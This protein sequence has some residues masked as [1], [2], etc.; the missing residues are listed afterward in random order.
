MKRGLLQI[1]W[2]VSFGIFVIFL[3]LL[4]ITFGPALTQEYDD[5]YLKSIAQKGF[6]EASFSEVLKYPIFVDPDITGGQDVYVVELP[7]KLKAVGEI[8]KLVVL[9]IDSSVIGQ[10]DLVGDNIIFYS[11]SA[12]AGSVNTFYLL[13]S[14]S[15]DSTTT[16]GVVPGSFDYNITFGVEEKIVGFS[17]KLFMDLSTLGYEEFKENLTYPKRKDISVRIYNGTDPS[18]LLYEYVEVNPLENDDVYVIKWADHMIG[19][20]GVRQPILVSI[21]TW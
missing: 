7:E 13:Y 19:E 15:F 3:L 21:G 20:N 4:F 5:D 11:I 6:K 2:M 16:P 12:V 10:R 8:S 17:E 1:D 14:D 18:I 9:D